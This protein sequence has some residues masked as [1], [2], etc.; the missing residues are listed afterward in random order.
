M[1]WKRQQWKQL[2][3]HLRLKHC[4]SFNVKIQKKCIS[5]CFLTW[6]KMDGY[7]RSACK[8][9]AK[10][11]KVFEHPALIFTTCPGVDDGMTSLLL[12]A[13]RMYPT[14]GYKYIREPLA[15]ICCAVI[16]SLHWY[17]S[18]NVLGGCFQLSL[19]CFGGCDV[20][21][22]TC[23]I[24]D[25]DSRCC[26]PAETCTLMAYHFCIMVG[27]CS[28]KPQAVLRS[29]TR[30]AWLCLVSLY[31][32]LPCRRSLGSWWLFLCLQL[33]SQFFSWNL[34]GLEMTWM[35]YLRSCVSAIDLMWSFDACKIK[36][37]AKWVHWI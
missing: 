30:P 2:W 1:V 19:S 35:V 18:P 32:C 4:T 8:A 36:G 15:K 11:K 22:R 13:L 3:N 25:G 5:R 6:L 9:C 33:S 23:V 29:V 12:M 34:V 10:Y 7:Q 14:S 26:P 31:A 16:S 21:S 24:C 28:L 17:L 27:Y 20:H 37:G